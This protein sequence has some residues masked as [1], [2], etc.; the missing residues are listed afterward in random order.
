MH[1]CNTPKQNVWYGIKKKKL[2]LDKTL[3]SWFLLVFNV[4]VNVIIVNFK[5]YYTI[6]LS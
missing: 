2:Y 5:I 4:Q 3:F 6:I 1:L